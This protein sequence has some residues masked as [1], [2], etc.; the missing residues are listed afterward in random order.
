MIAHMLHACG[1]YLGA[2]DELL[3]PASDNPDGYWEN[4]AFVDLNERLLSGSGTQWDGPL[5]SPLDFSAATATFRGEARSLARSLGTRGPWGW[6][7][8][9]NCLTVPF[10]RSVIPALRFVVCVRN[11]L[12]VALSLAARNQFSYERGLDLWYRYNASLL[13]T[14]SS[15][16]R[17][18]THYAQFLTN[19]SAE[20][21]RLCAFA[22]LKP[23]GQQFEH[24][25]TLSRRDSRHYQFGLHHLVSAGVSPGIVSLYARLCAE[26]HYD[27]QQM[28]VP[29]NEQL[30]V[31]SINTSAP[32]R[33]RAIIEVE[34]LRHQLALS[35]G[36]G[37][38]LSVRERALSV[39]LNGQSA[40]LTELRA[41]LVEAET[42]RSALAQ[43]AGERDAA[44][45]K[46]RSLSDEC[47]VLRRDLASAMGAAS[48]LQVQIRQ[49]SAIAQER[50]LRT[51]DLVT[52]VASLYPEIRELRSERL[53][54][55]TR[56]N[57]L[58][59]E[60]RQRD[61]TIADMRVEQ[62][63]LSAQLHQRD[64]RIANLERLLA[65]KEEINSRLHVSLG[66][67]QAAREGAEEASARVVSEN[68]ELAEELT[69]L[70]STG[71]RLES[72]IAKRSVALQA[73]EERAR[74]S[75]FELSTQLEQLR[76]TLLELENKIAATRERPAQG[77]RFR[78]TR[79][80][81]ELWQ[82]TGSAMDAV[83]GRT[84]RPK[85]QPLA[86][87]EAVAGHDWRWTSLGV[88]P[89]F[90]VLPPLPSGL[91][92]I[93]VTGLSSAE[94]AVTL[95]VDDGSGFTE[96]RAHRLGS[97]VPQAR[98]LT[99]EILLGRPRKIRLDPM[100]Q[101]GTFEIS[102]V[103]FRV[104]NAGTRILRAMRSVR[105]RRKAQLL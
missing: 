50:E 89:R 44:V 88:D 62:E 23:K 20:L 46:A 102:A 73:L 105:S 18:V 5:D 25:L 86:Q 7:D 60:L 51:R 2:P 40:Q 10:W 26:A 53:T 41:K 66:Q 35:R 38:A 9:R 17:I 77:W 56:V 15:D 74:T 83:W 70:R 79:S 68:L 81:A 78:W 21:R 49:N 71:A 84:Y 104:P 82:T 24:A 61:A 87:L 58:S 8:P 36:T 42:R 80:L 85:I 27:V 96:A 34:A 92:T 4:T 65:A 45:A 3:P 43:A 93:S 1:L 75:E 90:D 64:L 59:G 98:T 14:T 12:E 48:E 57:E 76:M 6:K 13:R 19:P 37:E 30:P 29:Q 55:Q 39:Q 103:V 69:K 95:Y 100:D 22:N 63:R 54:Q 72:E 52:Q 97:L 11:P 16:E 47:D 94:S 67:E 91:V 101:P 31:P 99:R 33:Q 32:L 28:D